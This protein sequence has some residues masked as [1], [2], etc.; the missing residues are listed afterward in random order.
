VGDGA[1]QAAALNNLALARA[2]AG[3]LEHALGPARTA[4][5]LCVAQGDRHREAALRGN[6]ADLL[7]DAGHLEDAMGELKRAVAVFAEVAA[8]EEPQPEIWKLVAW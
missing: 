2:A 4:L 1:T 6:L 7:H 8:D 3:D 5:A